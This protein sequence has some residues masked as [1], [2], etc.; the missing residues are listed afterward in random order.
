MKVDFFLLLGHIAPIAPPFE[1]GQVQ[2]CSPLL[3]DDVLVYNCA[4]FSHE[5]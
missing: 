2:G 5:H 1:Q 3:Y 4:H